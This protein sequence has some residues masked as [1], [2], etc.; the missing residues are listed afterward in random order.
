MVR[1]SVGGRLKRSEG[2]KDQS[3]QK[4]MN[5]AKRMGAEGKHRIE[6]VLYELKLLVHTI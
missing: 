4:G 6:A 5:Q 3:G 1:K 2:N